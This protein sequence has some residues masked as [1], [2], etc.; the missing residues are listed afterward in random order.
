MFYLGLLEM[1]KMIRYRHE[2]KKKALLGY[3]KIRPYRV[4]NA[5]WV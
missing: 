4:I 1:E 2:F 5:V 3:D